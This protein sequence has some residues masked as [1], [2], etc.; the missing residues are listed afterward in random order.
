MLFDHLPGMPCGSM[1]LAS[2]TQYFFGIS[3]SVIAVFLILLVL[4]QR[5]RGGGLAGAFGGMGGQ[6]A[7]GTK[8]GDT[9]TKVTIG[10]SIVWI[11]LCVA[12]VKLLGT[13]AGE[14]GQATAPAQ[15]EVIPGPGGANEPLLPGGDD[16]ASSEPSGSASDTGVPPTTGTPAAAPDTGPETQAAPTPEITP[17]TPLDTT[18]SS[19]SSDGNQN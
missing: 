3:L 8:A 1:L 11:L 13:S 5:G 9:F 12:S 17:S 14:F 6:S 10:A 16:G 18:N 7:F 2:F 15:T 4:V 19:G